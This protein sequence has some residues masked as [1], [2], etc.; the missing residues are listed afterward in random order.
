MNEGR[1]LLRRPWQSF[2]SFLSRA[3]WLILTPVHFFDESRMWFFHRNSP[4]NLARQAKAAL[5]KDHGN[6][7]VDHNS[8]WTPAMGFYVAC[9]GLVGRREYGI[10]KV[11]TVDFVLHLAENE[12]HLLPQLHH[13]QIID[14]SKASGLAKTIT[15]VQA[16]WFCASCIARLSDDK[17]IS[18]LELNTFGHCICTFLLYLFWWHKPYDVTSQTPVDHDICRYEALLSRCADCHGYND[19][20]KRRSRRSPD[21]RF[22]VYWRDRRKPEQSYEARVCAVILGFEEGFPRGRTHRVAAD[23]AIPGTSFILRPDSQKLGPQTS[24]L[25]TSDHNDVYCLSDEK[26][27]VW[28]ELCS[29]RARCPKLEASHHSRSGLE[30]RARH[31]LIPR[32]SNLAIEYTN[33][34]SMVVA[35][36]SFMLYGC[37]HLLA[38]LYEFS[39]V[40]EQR[41][42]QVAVVITISFA[43]AVASVVAFEV[44]VENLVSDRRALVCRFPSWWWC[45]C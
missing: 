40:A 41:L 10:P 36:F 21:S 32:S 38:W 17:A 24:A 4:L 26:L 1:G 6:A 19:Y 8:P 2:R 25:S 30:I 20:V 23:C 35:G 31:F 15:C 22:G 13:D 7:D 37:I 28:R 44:M 43:P 34:T 5:R 9:G 12:P 45:R 29:I 11:L 14:K 33:S 27:A 16:L 42:W 18:L 39:T 3:C